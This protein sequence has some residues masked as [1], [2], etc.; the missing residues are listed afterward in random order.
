[1]TR[2]RLKLDDREYHLQRIVCL[3]IVPSFEQVEYRLA[4][5]VESTIVKQ[6]EELGPNCRVSKFQWL[7]ATAE[8][9]GAITQDLGH[10][11]IENVLVFS[12]LVGTDWKFWCKPQGE[13]DEWEFDGVAAFL[14][15]QLG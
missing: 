9:C 5:E 8:P 11:G 6:V 2:G 7:I 10:Q 15:Q 4:P 13:V 1:M 12:T 14:Q 3:T